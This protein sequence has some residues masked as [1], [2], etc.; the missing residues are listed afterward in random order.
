MSKSLGN[1]IAPQEII[2]GYG[3]EILRIWVASEDY[4]DDIRIS[5]EILSRLTEAYRKI[6]N[7]CRFLLGNLYD[8]DNNDYSDKLQDVD[9]W[10]MS[11]MQSLIGRAT[12]AYENYDFHEAFHSIHNFCVV[13]MS[14]FYFDVLKDRLY[15]D[16]AD[17]T[18][19]R[20][21]QWV[22]SEILSALTGLMAPV[23]SFTAEEVYGYIRSRGAEESDKSGPESVFL[24]SFPVVRE[25]FIDMELEERW[26][27]LL[28]LRDEINKALEIKRAEKFIGN[29]LEARVRL[30]LPEKYMDLC[31]SYTDSL[32]AFFLVSAVEI[33]DTRL[34]GSY[35]SIKI[36]GLQVAVERAAGN[37]CLRCWGWSGSVGS[38]EDAPDVCEKCYKVIK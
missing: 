29:S 26:K 3:A 15:T 20:A 8:F 4:R 28:D 37:K 30:Y 2:K 25:E 34:T 31:R 5:K 16:R 17:S 32:P 12:R 1:V 35:E 27:G 7:T 13:D 36:E 9:R 6:R 23:L 21:S 22:L 24:S 33:A 18:E 14:S 38:F 11:R 10:A 19:R